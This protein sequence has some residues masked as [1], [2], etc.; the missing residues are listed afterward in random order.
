MVASFVVFLPLPLDFFGA[1]WKCWEYARGLM[2]FNYNLRECNKNRGGTE[3]D[4][5]GLSEETWKP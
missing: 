3:I 1:I 2:G 4:G 5:T